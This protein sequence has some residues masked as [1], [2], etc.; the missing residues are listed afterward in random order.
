MAEEALVSG[1][2]RGGREGPTLW[3]T[4]LDGDQVAPFL[5]FAY[6]M[7]DLE[8]FISHWHRLQMGLGGFARL[9]SMRPWSPGNCFY[10]CRYS[11]LNLLRILSALFPI[12]TG[13]VFHFPIP[14]FISILP[15]SLM[16]KFLDSPI[17]RIERPL[18]IFLG[19]TVPINMYFQFE[20]FVIF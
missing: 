7:I 5:V 6:L 19:W 20:C 10:H 2:S 15:S 16:T 4:R 17:R 3:A 13:S 9:S 1:V 18:L 14:P 8:R 12:S 11:V